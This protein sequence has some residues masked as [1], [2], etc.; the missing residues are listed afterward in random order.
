MQFECPICLE[1]R[2]GQPL[3]CRTCTSTA[4]AP[5]QLAWDSTLCMTCRA[6]YRRRDFEAVCGKRGVAAWRAFMTRTWV[7]REREL[8]V[9]TQ[10]WVRWQ[11]EVRR[12]T[13][14][15]RFGHTPELPPKPT[16]S[17]V[18]DSVF[19]C[20][21][22]ECNGFVGGPTCGTCDAVVCGR[23]RE[24]AGDRHACRPESVASVAALLAETQ[25]CPRCHAGIFKI[26]GC[27]HVI[28]ANCS[29]HFNWDT[30]RVIPRGAYGVVTPISRNFKPVV[31]GAG[32]DGCAPE[33]DALAALTDEV[34]EDAVPPAA[35]GEPVFALLYHEAAVGRFM[36]RERL[37]ARRVAARRAET[38]LALRIDHLRGVLDDDA[39]GRRVFLAET[40]ALR[41]SALADC[42]VTFLLCVNNA[43]LAWARSEWSDAAGAMAELAAGADVCNAHAAEVVAEHGGTPVRFDLTPP[44]GA[45]VIT[46]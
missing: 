37:N 43:Q 34:P 1:P 18:M 27:A 22:P 17:T 25:P 44:R 7:A 32:G 8:L 9:A 26:D 3:R 30:G 15:A 16:L 11:D 35:R 10:P 29:V 20:P 13:A 33:D 38:L 28:C 24:V 36:M 39:W 19:P 46:W 4:C 42:L 14:R 12:E 45:P 41:T 23:C 6:P 21:R 40:A 5:C 2:P 31:G